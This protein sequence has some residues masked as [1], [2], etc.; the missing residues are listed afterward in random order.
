MGGDPRARHW[1]E[2]CLLKGAL[3]GGTGFALDDRRPAAERVAPP[4]GSGVGGCG[5]PNPP[6]GHTEAV[7]LPITDSGRHG[8]FGTVHDGGVYPPGIKRI[9][10]PCTRTRCGDG[11]HS[12]FTQDPLQHLEPRLTSGNHESG[13]ESP[14]RAA[15]AGDRVA[16]HDPVGCFPSLGTKPCGSGH[17]LLADPPG[18]Y[19]GTFRRGIAGDH[20][21]RSRGG[22]EE[23]GNVDAE[24][25]RKCEGSV[26]SWQVPP[27]LSCTNE[28]AADSGTSR[29]FSLA[30]P[31]G[32]PARSKSGRHA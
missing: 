17:H 10:G 23:F 14:A 30:Q 32:L 5:E 1:S 8:S 31:G 24:R 20:I 16:G 19:Q 21:E 22:T 13:L 27:S 26:D 12:S 4:L 3:Y 2:G 6:L 18:A 29:Q 7:N 11:R 9:D 25:G 15:E 28:L